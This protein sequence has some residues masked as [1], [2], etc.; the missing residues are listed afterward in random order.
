MQE[1]R[2][3]NHII[4]TRYPAYIIA[5][6]G[7]NH[8]GSVE[9]AK[10]LIDASVEAGCD[11]VKFQKRDLKELYTQAAL[12]SPETQEH[13]IHYLLEHIQ[14]SELSEADMI[15]LAS[16]A[17]S[18]GV[19][20]MCTP[21]DE[22]SLRFL[23]T[24]D[25]PAFKIGSPDMGNLPLLRAAIALHKPLL[26]STGMS[27]LSEIRQVVQ[28][29]N[30]HQAEY[31]LLHCISSYPAPYYDVHLNFLQTLQSLTSFP[32]GY[33]GHEQ[34]VTVAV[35]AVAMGARVIEKHIS[36]DKT[37]P[38]PDQRVSLEPAEFKEL[39]RQVRLVEEA[40]GDSVRF[41]SRGEYLN[42]E[43]LSKSIVTKHALQIGDVITEQDLAVKS[44]GKGVSPLKMSF[45]LGKKVTKRAI[46]AEDYLLEQDVSTDES[47]LS[48]P[49]D[50][51]RPWGV[52]A[53]MCDIDELLKCR[54]PY[55]EIHLT[56]TDV[57][58]DVVNQTIYDRDLVVHGP[59]YD[60][61][62]LLNLSSLDESVRT[63][64][65]AFFQKSLEHARHLKP[66]F[67]N[68]E[69][70]VKFVVHPGGMHMERALLDKIP[71]LNER[72]FDSLSQLNHDG[73]ELLVENM[74]ACPWYFGGQWFHASFMNA[75][76]IVN[77]SRQTGYGVVFDLSHA[78]LYC[79]YYRQD[80]EKFTETILPVTRYL[81]ISDAAGYNGEGLQI[82]DGSVDFARILP[83][84]IKTDLWCLPEI[85]QGHKF[86]GEG[87]LTAIQ[88]L[89]T[90]HPL[91]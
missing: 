85:W 49:K 22:P 17:K 73:F 86:G 41:P 62:L 56:H 30:D 37:E 91:F 77:F 9:K 87:F 89:K 33:S 4:G 39:V 68:R 45:F 90:I 36:L 27:T 46:P 44:P 80:L 52:V 59:E 3:G 63:R 78:A 18:H 14:K 10:R 82:G 74:P 8:G 25:V 67:K 71:Q 19:D 54:S 84:I 6:I 12:N 28:F 53:R 64:S 34:G 81:H 2:F 47:D 72:L 21:W 1:I 69:Q 55:I 29:L 20:F 60:G 35:A 43:N 58:N 83:L 7:L 15:E 79:N 32:I 75:E 48:V 76:E 23:S 61:D 16:Y 57:H 11:C 66:L 70:P 31:V 5:E 88:R 38:G 24:L 42:H 50:I 51:R 26:V 13:A 65:I 40:F